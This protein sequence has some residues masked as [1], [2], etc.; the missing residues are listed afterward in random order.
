MFNV[1]LIVFITVTLLVERDLLLLARGSTGARIDTDML[2]S[3]CFKI[4]LFQRHVI[5]WQTERYGMH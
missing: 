2:P 5:S 4:L 3:L 1:D